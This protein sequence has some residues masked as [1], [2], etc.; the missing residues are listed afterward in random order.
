LKKE[1]AMKRTTREIKNDPLEKSVLFLFVFFRHHSFSI[2]FFK[3]IKSTNRTKEDDDLASFDHFAT[4]FPKTLSLK[5]SRSN[6]PPFPH[7]SPQRPQHPYTRQ[8][9]SVI[10]AQP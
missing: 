9:R 4:R 10:P 5:P 2:F 1:R 8:V 7:A 6:A 3:E